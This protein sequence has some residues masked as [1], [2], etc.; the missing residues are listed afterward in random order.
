M[1]RS[2]KFVYTGR[3]SDEVARTFEEDFAMS[4][5]YVDPQGPTDHQAVLFTFVGSISQADATRWN[6]AIYQLKQAFGAQL[7]GIT[8][9]GLPTPAQYVGRRRSVSRKARVVR[10]KKRPRK[11]RR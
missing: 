5:G 6:D 7:V 10:A 2:H 9:K 1:R 3:E 11:P 4:G 8:T